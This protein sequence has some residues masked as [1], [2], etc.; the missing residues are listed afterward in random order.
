M[1]LV[2]GQD[3][4]VVELDVQRPQRFPEAPGQEQVF[5]RGAALAPGVVV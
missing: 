4:V 1:D 5:G 3:Q 2:S